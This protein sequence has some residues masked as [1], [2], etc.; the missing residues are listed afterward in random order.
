MAASRTPAQ[1]PSPQPACRSAS[2]GK[3]NAQPSARP[4]AM[5][6][7]RPMTTAKPTSAN[8]SPRIVGLVDGTPR[9]ARSIETR[10]RRTV[11]PSNKAPPSSAHGWPNQKPPTSNKPPPV[12]PMW[13]ARA[14]ARGRGRSAPATTGRIWISAPNITCSMKPIVSRWVAARAP[15]VQREAKTP[16]PSIMISKP[17]SAANSGAVRKKRRGA[18][19][20][21]AFSNDSTAFEVLT[22]QVE[23]VSAGNQDLERAVGQQFGFVIMAVLTQYPV[24][25]M[26]LAEEQEQHFLA[27]LER[28]EHFHGRLEGAGRLHVTGVNNM[29]R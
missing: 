21:G 25:R 17:A 23:P 26:R 14:R 19:K 1:P 27:R 28:I 11:A 10:K 24:Q 7:P 29:G 4:S 16:G 22:R 8:F 5:S 9:R 13:T 3:G 6:K 18:A 12:S 15:G 2:T 20:G